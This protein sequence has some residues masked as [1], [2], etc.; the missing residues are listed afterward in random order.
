MVTEAINLLIG[1]RA[2]PTLVRPGAAEAVVEGRF[3]DASGAEFVVKRVIPA[4][5]RS[6]AYLNGSLSTAAVLAE[7]TGPLIEIHGQHGHQ[8]LL[9]APARRAALDRF[10]RIDASPL[11][12]VRDA[13]RTAE[14]ALG[15]LGGDEFARAREIELLEFQVSEIAGA[16][17]ADAA[18]DE[19][20]AARELL[21]GNATAIGEAAEAAIELLSADG[22]AGLAVGE[23]MAELDPSGPLAGAR[24]R[25]YSVQAE[26]ADVVTELRAVFSSIEDDPEALQE[27]QARRELLTGLRRKYGPSLGDV[28]TFGES[29]E[30]RLL[31]LRNHGAKAEELS[32]HIDDLRGELDRVAA[33]LLAARQAAAPGL[34]VEVLGEL[35]ELALPK[36]RFEVEVAGQSGADVDFLVSMNPG[37]PLL[38]VAK[39]ASGGELSRVMLAL[40][41]VVGGDAGSV[42]YDEVDSGVGG[43]AAL[44]IGKALAG[45]GRKHQVLV[46][47]HLPQV[48][49]C[50]DHQVQITKT[51]RGET[52]ITELH[53]LD[54]DGRVIELARDAF[55]LARQPKR[56]GSRGRIARIGRCPRPG[57]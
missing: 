11:R 46:V 38:P 6:R 56:P 45:V 28:V 3:V 57:G 24:E 22:P 49:A 10:G 54:R 9:R 48:A 15:E 42:V 44:A 20:L 25:L 35:R 33:E 30:A 53:D 13:L 26:L 8:T 27:V 23:A 21:L 12:A 36:A 31:D 1:G 43:A 29:A 18:E 16:R 17:I 47:T 19:R 51:V 2:E 14:A 7:T 55:R 5:G 34:A 39:V 32:R 52:T 37:S 41:L 40:Q 50:A 4:D